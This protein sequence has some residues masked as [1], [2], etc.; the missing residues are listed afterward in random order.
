MDVIQNEAI[1]GLNR[2]NVDVLT[3]NLQATSDRFEIGDLTRTDVAQSAVAAGAGARRPAHRRGEPDRARARRYIQLVG[4]R[5]RQTSQPPPPLPGLPAS[6]DEAVD[7]ALENNP[8]L[9]RRA[10]AQPRPPATTSRGRRRPPAAA[11]A[12]TGGSY[13]NYLGTLGGFAGGAVSP[14]R[15]HRAGRRAR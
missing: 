13:N 11:Q 1:V 3:V 15:D 9:H 14:R 4:K 8:D 2:N 6:P 12:F 10:G 5:A 7:V